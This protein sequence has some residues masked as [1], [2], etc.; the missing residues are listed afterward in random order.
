MGYIEFPPYY[1]TNE[2]GDTSGHLVD[3][4]RAII[5]EA[6]YDVAL[7]SYPPKR[8]AKAVVDGQADLYF[9]LPTLSDFKS[10]VIVSENSIDKISLRAY[11]LR[12]LPDV[13]T[14]H[15]LKGKTILILRGYSYG[16]WGD[17]IRNPLNRVKYQTA[18]SHEQALRILKRRP[19]DYLLDYKFPVQLAERYV[20]TP[21]LQHN[22]VFQLQ[23]H[24]IISKKVLDAETVLQKLEDAYEKLFPNGIESLKSS[25]TR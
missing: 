23:P 8:V 14:K 7:R 22:D 16:D 19:V 24:I 6:G 13:T 17:Y 9:G 4:A 3:L 25:Y 18:D 1:W 11:R 21:G 5:E 12:D 15:D 20:D 10:G 2:S